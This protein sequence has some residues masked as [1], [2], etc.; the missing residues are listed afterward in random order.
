M[1]RILIAGGYGAFGARAAER[2][3]R[4]PEHEIVI[5]GRSAERAAAAA[6]QLG[7]TAKARVSHTVIDAAT[8][9]PAELGGPE[10]PDI[11]LNTSGP[12]QTQDYALARACIAARCHYIDIADARPFVT[13]I[14]ALDAEARAAGVLVVSGASSVPGVSSAA[15]A[16]LAPRFARLEGLSIGISPGNHFDPGLATT[17]SVL[18]GIGRPLTIRREGAPKTVYGWQGLRREAMPGLG[19]RWMGYVDVPDLTLFPA[20]N[21]DLQNITFQAGVEVGL[22]HFGMWGLSWLVRAGLVRSPERL[23]APL[24]LL[25]HKLNFLGSDRGGM[26]VEMRGEAPDGSPLTLRWSLT[27]GSG[28]GPFVPILAAVALAGRLATGLERGT[29]ARPCFG[30]VPLDGIAAET[31]GLDIRFSTETL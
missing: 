9:T 6:L 21:L 17:Q 5:A 19:R 16:A 3:S 25:K 14:T 31:T 10:R 1:A 11:V 23:A 30:T 18:S 26:F 13:G 28:H 24:L 12:F 15:A 20:A 4:H 22:M 2:L 8:V 27:A 29:G 7:T